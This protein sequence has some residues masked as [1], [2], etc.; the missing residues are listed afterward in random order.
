M[1]LFTERLISITAQQVCLSCVR[2]VWPYVLS[3]W[4]Q[5]QMNLFMAQLE[6]TL[7][8]HLIP[9]LLSHDN[10]SGMSEDELAHKLRVVRSIILSGK[11]NRCATIGRY[12]D[13]I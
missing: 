12:Q 13:A 9:E 3:M 11:A 1:K 4:Q 2:V 6:S 5:I 7:Y 8:H 10:P